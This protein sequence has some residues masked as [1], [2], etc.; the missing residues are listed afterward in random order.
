MRCWGEQPTGTWQ[1]IVIDN[2]KGII[3]SVRTLIDCLLLFVNIGCN[4]R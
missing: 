2:G 1:L 3:D 4:E